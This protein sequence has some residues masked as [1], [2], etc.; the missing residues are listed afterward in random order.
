MPD[1]I[2]PW[3]A[4]TVRWALDY[5][6]GFFGGPASLREPVVAMLD[7]EPLLDARI[8]HLSKGQRKRVL[9]ALGLLTPS[10]VLLV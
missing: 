2:A 7:L 9:L 3:P 5:A 10:D 4:E 8:G 1:A 6:V